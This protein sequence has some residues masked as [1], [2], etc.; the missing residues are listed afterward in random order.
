MRKDDDVNVVVAPISA[1]AAVC[2]CFPIMLT[3]LIV[4]SFFI[5]VVRRYRCGGSGSQRA[6]ARDPGVLAV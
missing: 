2:D 6:A 4:P 3:L 5:F 1:T